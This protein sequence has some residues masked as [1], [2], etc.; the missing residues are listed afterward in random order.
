[1]VFWNLLLLFAAAF[2]EPV[3]LGSEQ[4]P[5]ARA[6]FVVEVLEDYFA[7]AALAAL[8]VEAERP[9]GRGRLRLRLALPHQL[10]LSN[11][12]QY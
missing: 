11:F 9:P 10:N 6:L 5:A 1:M 2:F 4:R 3:A 7:R 12:S 8:V